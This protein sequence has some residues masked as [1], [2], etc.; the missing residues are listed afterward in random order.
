[1]HCT[2][3]VTSLIR[4]IACAGERAQLDQRLQDRQPAERP[5]TD[6]CTMTPRRGGSR[7]VAR[8]WAADYDASPDMMTDCTTVSSDSSSSGSGSKLSSVCGSEFAAHVSN[9]GAVASV[10]PSRCLQP[11]DSQRHPYKPGG[12]PRLWRATPAPG[13][14]AARLVILALI[15]RHNSSC[16]IHPAK[17]FGQQVCTA[18]T[19]RC[20]EP[21]F[22]VRSRGCCVTGRGRRLHW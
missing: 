15:A 17:S 10:S 12:E 21:V 18:I 14:P 5:T 9:G 11:H 4:V 2:A 8:T 16:R 19:V 22:T 20:Q 13:T 1:M 6:E 7:A 3:F